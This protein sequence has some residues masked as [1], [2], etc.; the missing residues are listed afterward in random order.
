MSSVMVIP[1]SCI[2]F[3]GPPYRFQTFKRIYLTIA[4]AMIAETKESNT[5]THTHI[6]LRSSQL[7]VP[8][9]KISTKFDKDLHV[10]KLP[11]SLA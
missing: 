1:L 6:F 8:Q 5:R 9:C 7:R 11:T 3:G 10:F 2:G 4:N